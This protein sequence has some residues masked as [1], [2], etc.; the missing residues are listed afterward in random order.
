M[1]QFHSTNRLDN[2]YRK[3]G[4]IHTPFLEKINFQFNEY[5]MEACNIVLKSLVSSNI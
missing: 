3:Y 2:H 1:I 5:K 4:M